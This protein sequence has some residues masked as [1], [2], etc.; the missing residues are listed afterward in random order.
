MKKIFVIMT[1]AAAFLS[2]AS[3]KK[4]TVSSRDMN[5]TL[6]FAEFAISYD[7][8]VET[9]AMTKADV[10]ANGNYTISIYD[11]ATGDLAVSTTYSA[12]KQKD[13]KLSLPAGSYRLEASS[14]EAAIPVAA[15]EQPVYG[16]TREFS[17]TAGQTTSIGRLTCRLLQ[18]KVTVSYSDDFL[19]MVSGNGSASVEVTAGYPLEYALNY[20]NG[21]ATY[22]QSAGF[23][24]VNGTAGTTMV[25]TFKG[26]IDGK[27]QKMTKTFTDVKARQWRQV[28]FIK[29]VNEEGN[30]TFDIVINP[31]VDDE[32]LANDVSDAKENIIGDDPS[33]PKG[34]GGITLAFDYAAGCDAEFTDLQ[35][36]VIPQP[37]EKDIHLNLKSVIPNGVKKFYVDITST[38]DAFLAALDAANART[39]DLINPLAE[40][41]LI[42][43]VVPFPHGQEL[44]GKTELQFDLSA[45][46]DAIIMYPGT[47]TFKMNVVDNKGCRN[48]FDVIMIVNE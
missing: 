35:N 44:L 42:F 46:Q 20:A 3:C 34:D 16:A 32:E 2:L 13:N 5:G 41:D 18:C 17:I 30:A 47:H 6:S 15:F 14:S 11:T 22:D 1:A 36:I 23:F 29:K 33:A 24:S 45:A 7:D 43:K 19:A 9:K 28:K 37:S 38:S 31:L 8:A 40:H 48:A 39:I 21:S 27:S 12:V 26:N 25:V 10:A 4:V